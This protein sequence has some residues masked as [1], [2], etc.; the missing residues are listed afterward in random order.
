MQPPPR[1]G[2]YAKFLKNVHSEQAAKLQAKNQHECD[3]LEDIRSFVVKKS[4]IEKSYADALLKISSAYLNKK[5]PNIPDL[6]VDNADERWN[7]WN[8]WRTVLEENE[9][10][11]RARLAA[12]EIFQQQ[13]ADEAKSLKMHKVQIA[14]KSIDQL[15]VVQKELQTCVQDVDKTKKLYFDEEHCA[16]DV[17][18]KA[19]DIEEKLKKKKGS[20]FQSIT[21]LQKNSAKVSSKRDAL[22]EKSTGARNDYLLALAAANAHQNRYFVIDLQQTMLYMEQGVYDKVAEYLSIMGRTELLTCMAMQNSFGKIRDQA[23]Q[24]TREYNIQCC[25]L[26]YPVL[27][28][29]IQYEFEPCDN[30]QVDRITADN[31]AAQTL[32]KEARR[33]AT[34]IARE[35][36]TYRESNRKLVALQQLRDSG[37]KTDPND[38]NGP[39]LETKIDELKT[40]MRKAET[41]KMKAEAR[42]EC[43]RKGGV[44]VDEWLQEVETLSVQDIPRSASSLSIRTDASG[45]AP[46]SDSFYDSDN[47]AGSDLT[48]VERPGRGSAA[49]QHSLHHE[50]EDSGADE[51]QRHDSAEVDAASSYGH[52]AL[53]EQE[54]Q[55]IDEITAGWDDP[56][57]TNWGNDDSTVDDAGNVAEVHASADD[58]TTHIYKCTA[59]YSYTANNPDELS[60]VESEQL[61]VVGEG[62]GDG[63]LRARNYRGEEGY[64]PQNYLDVEREPEVQQSGLTSNSSGGLVQQISFSSVDYTIDDHD[65]V[66]PDAHLYQQQEAQETTPVPETQAP[67]STAPVAQNHVALDDGREY[68][69]A[70]YDYDASCDEELTFMEGD[71]IVVL[72]KEPHDV[73]DGWWEGEFNGQ[74]GLFPSL[75][76]EPCA[77]DGSPLSE[78]DEEDV[79][80]PSTSAP[81]VFTPPEAPEFVLNEELAQSLMNEMRERGYVNGDRPDSFNM[82]L[83]RDQKEQYGLQFDGE[84]TQDEQ[85]QPQQQQLQQQPTPGIVV[86]EVPDLPRSEDEEDEPEPVKVARE[87]K[88]K[89]ATGE[90]EDDTGLGVAQIVITAATPMEE[91]DRPFPGIEESEEEA[92]KDEEPAESQPAANGEQTDTRLPDDESQPQEEEPPPTTKAK[93]KSGESEEKSILDDQPTDSAPFPVSSSSGSDAESLSGPST[94]DNSQC[95]PSR[96]GGPAAI[97][98]PEDPAEEPAPKMLVGGRASIPDELQPD[99]LQ[100][101]QN[102][103]ESNA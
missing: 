48:T 52:S 71:V 65:A 23:E 47:D 10:L 60:I 72:K 89:Q 83:T 78:V 15:V 55:R 18:D 44:N 12:V 95:L 84:V 59:L 86:D 38:P 51:R 29:H 33:W 100:K 25:C 82:N 61:E 35:I 66:D 30:D 101:L 17:R 36:N 70:L 7:M 91:V 92:S 79:T 49:G 27:K 54:K 9:K 87:A 45:N 63:W 34:R 96:G 24:L 3:L 31:A 46:S 39:D 93:L 81:P 32:S 85:P 6:K 102:L 2:N 26:Y 37:Q 68:C 21:S 11:A 53:L 88:K 57:S 76:V 13:I 40:T 8:V 99:Q 4:A 69:V 28:Q 16:H 41:A 43:L 103:K 75:V 19:K 56:T 22:E 14:K 90:E 97:E 5:I 20:F 42:I 74:R 73:D 64:V 50:D 67:L 1:K 98:D 77:P 62:D 58:A 94:A 80:P